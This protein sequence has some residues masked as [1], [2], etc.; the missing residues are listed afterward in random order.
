MEAWIRSDVHYFLMTH[1]IKSGWENPCD[2][3]KSRDHAIS[4]E[5]LAPAVFGNFRIV[6][7]SCFALNFDMRS[8]V[9]FKWL[10]FKIVSSLLMSI[11]SRI[12]SHY[13]S[14]REVE[15]CSRALVCVCVW[16]EGFMRAD[17]WWDLLPTKIN[18]AKKKTNTNNIG[19]Y[20]ETEEGGGEKPIKNIG[21]ISRKREVDQS[22]CLIYWLVS[23]R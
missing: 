18:K 23:K 7:R 1:H 9:F 21:D 10:I 20:R 11:P 14:S 13:F 2:V 22:V 8:F 3:T 12:F 6:C 16:G 4:P 15:K 19:T 17:L 5:I